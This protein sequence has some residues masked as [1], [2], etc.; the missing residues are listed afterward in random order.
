[1]QL[2]YSV[3][4]SLFMQ[5]RTGLAQEVYHHGRHDVSDTD[6]ITCSPCSQSRG[7]D[8]LPS[9]AQFW[10]LSSALEQVQS[11]DAVHGTASPSRMFLQQL[12]PSCLA[13]TQPT[14][15]LLLS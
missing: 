10:Y 5:I 11:E 1:M 13:H 12:R 6:D 8:S 7:C 9:C 14:F 2:D 15:G 3:R 4:G